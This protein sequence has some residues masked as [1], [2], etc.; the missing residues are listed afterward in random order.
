MN[1]RNTNDVLNRD[2]V[3]RHIHISYLWQINGM[4]N[5][6]A[7]QSVHRSLHRQHKVLYIGLVQHHKRYLGDVNRSLIGWNVLFNMDE[8][9]LGDLHR[10]LLGR[11]HL[12]DHDEVDLGDLDGVL[13]CGHD[14]LN[15]DKVDLGDFNRE[16]SGFRLFDL[17]GLDLCGDFNDHGRWGREHD[18]FYDGLN[19]D[20]SG[21]WDDHSFDHRFDDSGSLGDSNWLNNSFDDRSCYY[22][23][24][25]DWSSFDHGSDSLNNWSWSF[26][27]RSEGWSLKSFDHLWRV[28]H[29]DGSWSHGDRPVISNRICSNSSGRNWS[30]SSGS[31]CVSCL[32]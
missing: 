29:F 26:K 14:L 4:L 8:S 1:L 16:F 28:D 18:S 11:D 6:L 15:A 32:G 19:D 20:G 9:Y 30:V 21:G 22:W 23:S 5:R 25:D 10:V 13:V 24:F 7:L 31:V 17:H 2:S 12:L 3:L 27:D